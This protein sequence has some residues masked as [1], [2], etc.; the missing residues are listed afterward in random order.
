MLVELRCEIRI[1]E[2]RNERL[3]I[4]CCGTN[5]AK[6]YG[7][8]DRGQTHSSKRIRTTAMLKIGLISA[9][10]PF[11][12]NNFSGTVYYIHHALARLPGVEVTVIG[13]QFHRAAWSS[14][15]YKSLTNGR[16]A[17]LT[18]VRDRLF[19]Q[20]M[21]IMERDLAKFGPELDVIV[22]PVASEILAGLKSVRSL[23]P[24][25]FVTDATPQFI[26]ETYPLPVD[27]LAFDQERKVLKMAS[28]VIYSSHFMAS[29]A[30]VEFSDVLRGH[31][32]KLEVVPF[33]LNMDSVPSQGERKGLTSPL[34]LLFVGK[35]WG[36]KGGDIAVDMLKTLTE[37][38]I[39]AR[40]TV[41]GCEPDSRVPR[42]VEVIPYLNKNVPA[43]QR[44]YVDILRRSHFLVLPTRADCTP[45][46]IAEA[47]A[48]S[49][50]AIVADIG[51]I[52]TLVDHG[53]NGYL[54]PGSAEGSAYADM[55]ME[56]LRQPEQYPPLTLSCRRIYEERLNWDAWSERVEEF[57]NSLQ[58]VT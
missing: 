36:R 31:E 32:D 43:Q 14:R 37:R 9:H 54:M 11:D 17:S 19:K 12:R 40:L 22:A 26:R 27:D 20:F 16:F 49:M 23:P 58:P 6:G 50:P 21:A 38:G 44:R 5:P 51:G 47:N 35:D 18:W 7:A 55:A 24:I 28:K 15:A 45:M 4:S 10:N 33:G 25:I 3:S 29:R 48:F 46:V 41:I 53:V 1:F 52:A 42:N 13:E 39:E 34:E 30:R 56:V 2:P 8:A 57:A